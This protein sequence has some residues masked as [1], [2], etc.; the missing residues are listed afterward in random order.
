MYVGKIG[1]I[2]EAGW[3]LAV[4]GVV[5]ATITKKLMNNSLQNSRKFLI[6]GAEGLGPSMTTC[7]NMAEGSLEH[8]MRKPRDVRSRSGSFTAT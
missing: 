6:S 2:G 8:G 3:G 5:G 1:G 7:L 4:G